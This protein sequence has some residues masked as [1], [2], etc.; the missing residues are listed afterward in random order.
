[1]LFG[2]FLLGKGGEGHNMTGDGDTRRRGYMTLLLE[3]S[4]GTCVPYQFFICFPF[5]IPGKLHDT[6]VARILH[7]LDSCCNLL[8]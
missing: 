3:M 8:P 1:M 7:L 6:V 4:C 5:L 2:C